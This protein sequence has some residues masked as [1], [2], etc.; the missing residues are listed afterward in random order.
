LRPTEVDALQ[1]NAA[2]ARQR[3]GREPRVVFK[4][5]VKMTMAHDLDLAPRVGVLKT[6]GYDGPVLGL[7][8][9][10]AEGGGDAVFEHP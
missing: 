4:E 5:L 6:A 1:R 8:A 9:S 3:L 10:E 2:K 7:A